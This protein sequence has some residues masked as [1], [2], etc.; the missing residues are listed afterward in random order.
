M[1]SLELLPNHNMIKFHGEADL[2]NI[3]K[4][5]GVI[6]GFSGEDLQ[7]VGRGAGVEIIAAEGTANPPTLKVDTTSRN[8][9]RP[10]P[11]PCCRCPPSPSP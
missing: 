3:V 4:E 8:A 6:S 10:P 1:E 11:W 2:G 9:I 5:D 7:L